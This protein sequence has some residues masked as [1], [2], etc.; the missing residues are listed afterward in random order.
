MQNQQP[1]NV[2]LAP[3]RLR[4]L[5]SIVDGLLCTL[6]LLILCNFFV[7]KTDFNI[8]PLNLIP[9]NL[10]F[11]VLFAVLIIIL[12]DQPLFPYFIFVLLRM[13]NPSSLFFPSS[14][15]SEKIPN[16]GTNNLNIYGNGYWE[17][18]SFITNVLNVLFIFYLIL[19]GI[20]FCFLLTQGQTIGKK[21]MNLRIIR[22]VN[23]SDGGFI[24][25]KVIRY[26]VN[27]TGI[28]LIRYLFNSFLFFLFI[29][30]L[31]FVINVNSSLCLLVGMLFYE[32]L[33]IL[34]ILLPN[35]RCFHDILAG[36]CVVK[37]R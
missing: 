23:K 9:Y 19:I 25:N 2:P 21:I 17:S 32:L 7:K 31:L 36:T 29:F 8:N 16:I 12:L 4:F 11:I 6:P 18:S 26:T 1:I 30:F 37:N 13:I 34:L 3:R 14:Y 5:A 20:Q 27:F 10:E 24:Q 28:I 22:F 15:T 33:D 35:R